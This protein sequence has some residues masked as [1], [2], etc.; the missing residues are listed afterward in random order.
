MT[1]ARHDATT[2]NCRRASGSPM[3]HRLMAVALG[4]ALAIGGRTAGAQISVDD[5]ELR[6]R[7]TS[8][9]AVTGTIKIN[10]SADRASQVMLSVGDWRRDLNGVNEFPPLGTVDGSCGRHIQVFPSS[11]VVRANGSEAIRVQ[12]ITD[13]L[14]PAGCW[15]MVF[16]EPVERAAQ[17][18]GSAVYYVVRSGVKVYVAR[19]GAIGDAE[20]LGMAIADSADAGAIIRTAAVRFHN[21][22]TTHL[23]AHGTLEIRREDNSVVEKVEIPDFYTTPGAERR[24]AAR[25]PA[26]L[27]PGAYIALAMIDF[28]GHEIL[29]DQLA[30]IV[31]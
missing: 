26:G 10:N 23:V 20:L 11:V 15:A 9:G 28:D 5:L 8:K 30:F 17:Q 16:V 22:G 24:V 7:A 27:A 18:K 14:A 19:D 12:V 6:L 29:A 21:T 1:R 3:R 25:L 31:P 2:G 4:A 13:S